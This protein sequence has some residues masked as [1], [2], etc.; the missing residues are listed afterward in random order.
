LTLSLVYFQKFLDEHPLRFT[1]NVRTSRIITGCAEEKDDEK[2]DQAEMQE[3][4]RKIIE[5]ERYWCIVAESQ[6]SNCDT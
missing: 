1:R 3:R 2:I 4:R 6:D 5:G